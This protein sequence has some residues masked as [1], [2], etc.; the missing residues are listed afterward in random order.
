MFSEIMTEPF[1]YRLPHDMSKT[2]NA[3]QVIISNCWPRIASTPAYQDEIIKALVT[4]YLN[5]HDDKQGTSSL[6]GPLSLA[7]SMLS[8]AMASGGSEEIPTT[9]KDKVAPLIAREAVLADLFKCI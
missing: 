7:A 4:C 3:L 1:T 6:Q 5:A 8:R 9:L 2:I